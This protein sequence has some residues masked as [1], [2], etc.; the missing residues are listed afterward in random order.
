MAV[1][2]S[3]LYL[4]VHD[5]HH[6]A[7]RYVCIHLGRALLSG[8]SGLRGLLP[9]ERGSIYPPMSLHVRVRDLVDHLPSPD[10]GKHS[11]PAPTTISA[12]TQNP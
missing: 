5:S 11:L 6:F 2:P 12:L 4:L 10:A 1:I 7:Y 9:F 3:L 8:E